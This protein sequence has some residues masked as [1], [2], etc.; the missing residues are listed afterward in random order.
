MHNF[1]S[2]L[3]HM[4]NNKGWSFFFFFSPQFYVWCYFSAKWLS[5]LASTSLSN[6]LQQ[7]WKSNRAS[8]LCY[9]RFKSGIWLGN[10]WFLLVQTQ[11]T[12][13]IN[14]VNRR[15]IPLLLQSHKINYLLF[16]LVKFSSTNEVGFD[17]YFYSF[18]GKKWASST[19]CSLFWIIHDKENLLKQKRAASKE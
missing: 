17:Y 16:F 10:F 15:K 6:S 11:A 2:Q 9:R 1:L 19:S 18:H 4:N 14:P 5:S 7:A 12:V 3:G 13:P 8:G